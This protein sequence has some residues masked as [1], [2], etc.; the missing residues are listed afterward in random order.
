[1]KNYTNIEINVEEFLQ[2]KQISTE[3][4]GHELRCKCPITEHQ[5]DK[6]GEYGF[7]ISKSTGQYMCHKCGEKGNI[8]TLCKK[9]NWDLPS[10][11]QKQKTE[12]I[13]KKQ[14]SRE[15]I[16]L[17][18]ENH[19]YLKS[20]V[21]SEDIIDI[22]DFTEKYHKGSWYISMPVYTP[23]G[24]LEGNKLRQFPSL[25]KSKL[26]EQSKTKAQLYGL[27]II[28][29]HPTLSKDIVV[30]TEGELDAL[31]VMSQGYAS[32]SGTNGAMT[33]QNNWSELLK[34][35]E[36][37]Y[38]VLDNDE[39]GKKGTRKIA[40]SLWKI[41]GSGVYIVDLP[42][43]SAGKDIGEFIQAG[44]SVEYILNNYATE[45][46]EKIS[47]DGFS[48]MGVAEIAQALDPIIKYD[49]ITKVSLFVS[50]I[51]AFTEKHVINIAVNGGSS[52]GKTYNAKNIVG[53]FPVENVFELGNVSKRAFLHMQGEY[54]KETNTI[55]LDFENK[56]ILL[57]DTPNT[58]VM[59]TLRS[60]MSQD[61]KE[62]TFAITDKNEG[63][64]QK[65]KNIKLRGPAMFVICTAGLH[66]DEQEATR[67]LVL[68]P[69]VSQAKSRMAIDYRIAEASDHTGFKTNTVE[70]SSI[71]MLRS[72]LLA[73]KHQRITQVDMPD[74]EYLESVYFKNTKSLQPRHA[75]DF[76]RFKALVAGFAMLNF[77]W[78][79]KRD[80][81]TLIATRFDI[82]QAGILWQ[83]LSEPQ[84]LGVAPQI[85]SL[86]RE[87]I[88]SAYEDLGCTKGITIK[89]IKSKYHK[90]HN[91]DINDNYL[92]NQIIPTLEIA[93]IIEMN[94]DIS[95]KRI[96]RITPIYGMTIDENN[97]T[98][99]VG[100][101]NS[102]DD[103]TASFEDIQIIS[104]TL[105]PQSHSNYSYE[106]DPM[107]GDNS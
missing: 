12:V 94:Q 97:S 32:V 82:E 6:A 34:G 21:L 58:E 56:I 107:Y 78:R 46:P 91:A 37:I 81:E 33:W 45:Y 22:A 73:I 44:V 60:F 14:A 40:E 83:E 28:N 96:K 30:I 42:I 84:E 87:V 57:L 93:G 38:I 16:V 61:A 79:Q 23:L 27:H 76:I 24:E 2:G 26:W 20:R 7:C 18:A 47:V 80:R 5:N 15:K 74:S 104:D 69:E 43:D 13:K 70:H 90:V 36:K 92:R 66:R 49:Y 52:T 35:Y 54:D 59:E 86:Y 63:G 100:V 3:S 19:E 67:L 41:K 88:V 77:I 4:H 105:L 85:L 53:L 17:S 51:G 103:N 29:N 71:Q 1:M 55:T 99:S 31:A 8:I 9:L 101:E 89:D 39:A 106:D 68:S 48:E 75:R 62:I 72:R 102:V 50:C 11:L 10:E 64:G 95:D 65:T 98:A 25:G